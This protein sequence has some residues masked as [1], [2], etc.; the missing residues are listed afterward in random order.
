LRF[1]GRIWRE[2]ET[3]AGD[4][5][6]LNGLWGPSSNDVF[7]VGRFGA[8]HF[9][10]MTWSPLDTDTTVLH[11]LSGH[12]RRPTGS[13]TPPLPPAAADGKRPRIPRPGTTVWRG[14]FPWPTRTA[15][16][17]RA[18]QR[19]MRARHLGVGLVIPSTYPAKSC[20]PPG[21]SRC[22]HARRRDR[23]ARPRVSACGRASREARRR[24][25]GS[26]TEPPCTVDPRVCL[27]GAGIRSTPDGSVVGQ[28][29]RARRVGEDACSN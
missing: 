2:Q 7:A 26:A 9:D 23:S 17:P 6:D 20:T 10:G 11:A 1:N 24:P 8:L 29:Q 5:V 22:R 12:D 27:G 15:N 21:S 13:P 14:L 25:P 19:A 3:G 4:W 28:P 18:A 16:W